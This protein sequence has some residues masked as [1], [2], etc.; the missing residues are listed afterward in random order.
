MDG[1]GSFT[2]SKT[3]YK[4]LSKIA[5]TMNTIKQTKDPALRK[6]QA[7]QLAA[8]ANSMLISEHLFGDGNGRTCRLF[9]DTIL[10]SF[11]LP[12]HTPNEKMMNVAKTMGKEMDFN[13]ATN[14]FMSG[15]KKSD[16]LLKQERERQKSLPGEKARLNSQISSLETSV[17]KTA[18]EAKEMLAALESMKK[19]GHKN[20]QDYIDMHDALEDVSNLDPK[21]HS[22]ENIERVLKNLDTAAK[23]YQKSHT[24]LFVATKGYGADRLDMSK[25][26]QKFS[27]FRQD[28][29]K[30]W[31]KDLDK[32][33]PISSQRQAVS[34]VSVN[35]ENK[36]VERMNMKEF[37]EKKLGLDSV[38]HMGDNKNKKTV[39]KKQIKN[40]VENKEQSLNDDWVILS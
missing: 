39:N 3:A 5:D 22:I 31:S 17:E 25:K 16:E 23:Q 8:F 15:I 27:T 13:K 4:T 21:E 11:G 40:K 38:V 26:L 1:V 7:V 33:A 2:A 9:A 34:E 30:G 18:S 6:T 24:G 12:P 35:H 20:G 28:V 19:E 10:Q 36:G 14:L 29:I 37:G 32:N